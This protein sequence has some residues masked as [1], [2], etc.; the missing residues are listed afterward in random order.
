MEQQVKNILTGVTNETLEKLAFLF[1]FPDDERDSDGP[2]PAI[3]GRVGFNGSF[4]G[5]LVIISTT[6]IQNEMS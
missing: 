2:Q 1:A 4:S 6:D 5:S 3:A